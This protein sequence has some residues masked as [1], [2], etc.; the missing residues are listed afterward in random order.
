MDNSV[1]GGGVLM[2]VERHPQASAEL[3][4]RNEVSGVEDLAGKPVKKAKLR[5]VEKTGS[6]DE[7]KVTR[8]DIITK[9]MRAAIKE[10]C[11]DEKKAWVTAAEDKKLVD[12]SSA[13]KPDRV[14]DTVSETIAVEMS[15][16][17]ESDAVD[18]GP[19]NTS[20]GGQEVQVA[21]RP[22]IENGWINE[23]GSVPW[24][25][26]HLR[27]ERGKTRS[28]MCCPP[29]VGGHALLRQFGGGRGP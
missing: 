9:K 2:D 5:V 14:C 8:V 22:M 10:L 4:K 20:S 23:S 29:D 6:H 19:V 1:E 7:T 26:Y 12:S 3:T 18:T 21:S 28:V 15:A 25:G 17:G 11:S 13:S 24:S 27:R 16:N